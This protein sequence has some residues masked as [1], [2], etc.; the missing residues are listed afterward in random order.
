MDAVRRDYLGIALVISVMVLAVWLNA[1]PAAR[2]P[3]GIALIGLA[4]LL[5]V[6][7][8]VRPR[9]PDA[10]DVPLWNKIGLSI[11]TALFGVSKLWPQYDHLSTVGVLCMFLPQLPQMIRSWRDL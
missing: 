3:L 9:S 10:P 8:V 1:I 2:V 6:M 5:W 4:I 7:P 11:G